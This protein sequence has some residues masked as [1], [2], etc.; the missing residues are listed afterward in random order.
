MGLE[1]HAVVRHSVLKPHPHR[2][3]VD[4][5]QQIV[6]RVGIVECDHR[7]SHRGDDAGPKGSPFSVVPEPLA[8]AEKEVPQNSQFRSD[9]N[10]LL[11]VIRMG[12]I[13]G[14]MHCETLCIHHCHRHAHLE[15]QR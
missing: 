8:A 12:C 3:T 4:I 6:H 7:P 10:P 5:R 14:N 11:V 13:G 1:P 9:V 2:E 15:K